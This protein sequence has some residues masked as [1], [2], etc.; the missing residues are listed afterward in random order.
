MKKPLDFNNILYCFHKLPFLETI[1]WKHTFVGQRTYGNDLHWHFIVMYTLLM[2]II[3]PSM[4]NY[5]IPC[6]VEFHGMLLI[7]CLKV[8]STQARDQTFS[9]KLIRRVYYRY[10]SYIPR[11]CTESVYIPNVFL[12]TRP[13]SYVNIYIVN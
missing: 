11:V 8:L 2:L 9:H 1:F 7:N 4:V 3:S 5:K 10:G 13:I 6:Y 12:M